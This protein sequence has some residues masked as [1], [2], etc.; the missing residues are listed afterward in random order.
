MQPWTSLGLGRLIPLNACVCVCLNTQVDTLLTWAYHHHTHTHTHTE[1]DNPPRP[2]KRAAC[3]WFPPPPPLSPSLSLSLSI[4]Y[5]PPH[6][7]LT[8][9][10]IRRFLPLQCSSQAVR[11][12]QY[13]LRSHLVSRR[14]YP[15]WLTVSTGTFSPRQVGRSALPRDTTSFGTAGIRTNNLLIDSPTP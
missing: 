11:G 4:Q 15:E 7:Y 5:V 1:T 8:P 13:I 10:Q 6:V 12:S 9:V 14:S 2:K 3:G